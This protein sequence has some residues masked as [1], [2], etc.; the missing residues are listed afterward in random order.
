MSSRRELANA[1]RALSMDAVQKANS[2]HPGAPMGMADIAEVLWNDFLKH[3]PSNPNWA[4]RDRFVLSNGHGSMLIYSLLHLSGYDLPMSEL[5]QFRQLHSKTP[6]HP[7]LGYTPG[8]ETTTG[9]L[10]QGISNAV[11]MALAEKMLAAQFNRDG[12]DIVDHYTYC[13]LGDGCLMEGVSHETC[14]LAGTLGLGK[15][16]AFWDDNGISIDGHVEGWFTDN[17]PARFE[18]YGWHVIPAVDGHD[19]EAIKAA[20]E[21]AQA[22]TGKPTLICTKTTIGF[23]SPNKSGSH[24]CHGAPLGDAEIAAAREFLGWPHAP[25]EIPDNVYAGWDAKEK[26]AAAQSAWEAKFEA[27][28]AAQPALAAEFERRVLNGDLPADFEAK[29]DAFIKAVNEKGESI[30]TRKASQNTIAEFGAALPELLGGSADLAGSNLTMWSGSKPVTRED[31]SG[32]YIYYGVREF[33]MSAIMNG[34]AAHGGFIN[35]GA[36]FLMFMEYARNAVRMSALMKLPNIF[37]YTHDSIGQGEDGPTHQPIEQLAALRLTP[38][39]NT[40]RPADAV[41]SAVAWKSAVM[42]KDGPSALVFT[43]QGVKAQSH[44][45]EQIANMARGAY[46]L[47][48]CDGEPEVMLIATGSEVGITVDAAAQLAGEGVKVRVVSMPCTNVFDQQDA[49][50]KE[51]VLPIAVTHR[52]AVETSHVDYWAKYV[53]IDGRVVGMT[54]FGESAPGGAL[55]EYFGFTVENVVNTVKELLED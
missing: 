17:T 43:R 4:D 45:D 9:P 51:S 8:V 16:I 48:D 14:S 11:G 21:A 24:D 34:I 49:A 50:Y 3:N 44:D 6:G 41:E 53:G 22:E 37:V 35:Y 30:A 2:G 46:V 7:E 28:K 42:R 40:W 5:A 54:T 13:F 55:L 25:F 47:V 38:N 1:I 23:G 19:P 52:V 36:T 31:A 39:L 27:Y 29:A 26:G 33:G 18:A 20:V 12:H 32:N 15:L 10:G